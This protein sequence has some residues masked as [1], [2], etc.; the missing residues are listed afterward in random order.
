MHAYRREGP[1]VDVEALCWEVIDGEETSALALDLSWKGLRLERPYLGG[2]A[3]R[4]VPLQIELP[5]ID[6]VMWARGH[7]CFDILVPTESPRGGPLGL[8]R[9]TGYRIAAAASRDLRLLK[10]YVVETHRAR[11]RA[12]I[13]SAL[14]RCFAARSGA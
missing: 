6:E 11:T 10:D 4:Q 1:R 2:P 3:R 9:R 7:A 14:A 8:I 13:E 5:G 12:M